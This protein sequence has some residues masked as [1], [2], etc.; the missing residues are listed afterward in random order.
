M[1]FLERKIREMEEG[2]REDGVAVDG[3]AWEAL[4]VLKKYEGETGL[5]Q[6]IVEGLVDRVVIYDPEHVEVRWKLVNEA[7]EMMQGK[8]K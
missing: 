1:D 4:D 5:T 3:E 7:V 2:I 8:K 6:E